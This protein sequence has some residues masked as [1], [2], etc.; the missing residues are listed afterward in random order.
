M[1]ELPVLGERYELRAQLGAGA[2]GAVYRA[3]DRVLGR[4]IA[5]KWMLEIPTAED[6]RRFRREATLASSFRHP[7]VI[8][9]FDVGEHAGKPYL[10]MELVAA[11]SLA[12]ALVELIDP[13]TI[14][15]T[16][17]LA[18]MVATL[19]E[20]AHAAGVVHRDLKPA[21]VFVEG[22]LGSPTRCRLSDF[23]LAFMMNPTQDTLG[24]FTVEGVLLGTPLYMAPEQ[25][26]GKTVGASVDVYALGCMIHE[27]LSGRPPFV[28]NVARVLA[29]HAYLPPIPLRELDAEVPPELEGLVLDMLAKD[30]SL[31]PSAGEVSRR[32][33]EL[34]E[35]SGRKR[36]A[37]LQPRS[38]R[39]LAPAIRNSV[40]PVD[41]RLR[42]DHDDPA[43]VEQLRAHDVTITD[44]ARVVLTRSATP[45]KGPTIRLVA[46]P[47]TADLAVAIRNGLAGVA[48][49]PGPIEPVLAQ[50]LRAWRRA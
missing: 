48:R 25:A 11:P 8:E 6:A 43:L 26:E 7:D 38:A 5:V 41:R 29:G 34:G 21:N 37:T 44:D 50:L 16:V 28:G 47:T 24:R 15:G 23:G 32:L 4:E 14:T 20:A 39:A 18:A 19:I 1:P 40:A 35:T 36:S 45:S 10:A 3:H 2:S 42:I 33:R 46:S 22:T 31:R 12:S 17:K 27:M 13:P 30:P 49:W 9:V